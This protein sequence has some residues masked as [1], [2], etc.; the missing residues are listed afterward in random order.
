[1][2][3]SIAELSVSC[4]RLTC[5]SCWPAASTASTSHRKAERQ[6]AEILAVAHQHVEGLELDLMY[7]ADLSAAR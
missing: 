2:T 3:R 1:M 4:A 6:L 7:R 5:P